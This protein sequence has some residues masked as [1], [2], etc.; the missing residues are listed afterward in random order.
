M[1]LL[2]CVLTPTIQAQNNP[3]YFPIHFQVEL[4]QPQWVQQMYSDDPNVFEVDRL[5]HEDVD[6]NNSSIL[7]HINN[8]Q[9]WRKE[10]DQY[11]NK[12]GFIR[13]L[14]NEQESQKYLRDKNSRSL[15][16]SR[17]SS[18]WECIGPLE[19]FRNGSTDSYSYQ[20]SIY[21]LDQS[22]SNSSILYAGTESGGVFK[23]FNKGIS[24]ILVSN[25]EEFVRGISA[26]E[27]HPSDQNK[28]LIGANR[29]IYS[30]T[31]AGNNWNEILF[32]N[33]VP[34]EIRFNPNDPNN[35]YVSCSSGFYATTD[36]G[37]NWNS[38]WSEPTYDI[39]FQPNNPDSIFALRGNIG[40]SSPELIRTVDGGINWTTSNQGWYVPEDN[41]SA[42]LAGG[43]IAIS[44]AAPNKIY[45]GLV[46][47]SKAGDLGWIGVYRSDNGGDSW[48]LPAG[49]IGGPYSSPNTMPWAIASDANN[50]YEGF[51]AFD[52][53]VSET[54]SDKL[55]VGTIR[56]SESSD[57][58]VSFVSIGGENSTRLSHMHR[59][60][61]DLEVNG[62][63]IWVASDGGINYSFNELGFHISTKRG[64]SSA[65][66]LGFDSGWN[67][68]I[69]VGG[70][71][72][73]GNSAF[74]EEFNSGE[75]THLGGNEEATGYLNPFNNKVYLG[76]GTTT[77]V[78]SLPN[79]IGQNSIQIGVLD[80]RP[81]ESLETLSSSEITFDPRY[82][83]HL[84][85][86]NDNQIWFSRNGGASF[87]LLHSF[88]T[89][90]QVLSIKI[91]RNNP[92]Y[93]YCS[94]RS[95]TTQGDD[96]NLYQSTD[97][98]N[99]WNSLTAPTTDLTGIAFSLNPTNA[100]E[101]WISSLNGTNGQKVFQSINGGASW[102]NKTTASLDDQ[103]IFDILFQ[104]GTNS[105][106]HLACEAGVRYWENGTGD[107]IDYSN[108]LPLYPLPLKFKPFYKENK[109]RL[110]SSGRGIW[111]VDFE[112]SSLPLA[113]PM[114]LTDSI[115]CERDS[116]S[117]DCHS[118]LTHDDVDWEWSFSPSPTFVDD[119]N[120]RNPKVVFGA[121]GNYDVTLTVTDENGNVSTKILSDM[122]KINA[123]CSVDT[124]PG[125]ALSLTGADNGYVDIGTL[126]I[127]S[128]NITI[129]S[130]IKPDDI[131][132]SNA[133]LVFSR[134]NG[135]AS[136][137]FITESRELRFAW[138]GGHFG[139][140]SG[141][142]VPQDEWSHV[143]L[144]V[145]PLE[146]TL[147]LNG[148]GVSRSATYNPIDFNSEMSIGRDPGFSNRCFTGEMDEVSIF[149]RALTEEE[150]RLM[151][152]LVLEPLND[153]TI[154]HYYQFNESAGPIIDKASLSHGTLVG[155]S[156]RS[157]SPIPVGSGIVE[158][159]NIIDGGEKDFST[160]DVRMVFPSTGTYPDGDVYVFKIN[161]DPNVLPHPDMAHEGQ[162]WIFNNYGNNTVF[163]ALDSIEFTGMT[164]IDVS[165][166]DKYEIFKR[167]SNSTDA[168]WG[169][170]LG[171]ADSGNSN[172]LKFG[173]S[174]NLNSFS[175]FGLAQSAILPLD[176]LSIQLSPQINHKVKVDWWTANEENVL[177]QE[178]QRSSNGR[179]FINVE[180]V[181]PTGNPR[182]NSY[183]VIDNYPFPGK[184]YYRIKVINS[185]GSFQFSE[186]KTL[187]LDEVRNTFELFPNPI[188]KNDLQ[189]NIQTLYRG[190][191]QFEIWSIEGRKLM[192]DNLEGPAKIDLDYLPAG[193]YTWRVVSER[194]MFA[195][196]LIVN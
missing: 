139:W 146:T 13:P 170:A 50:I 186:I 183:S 152:H 141:L 105:R 70:K 116:V 138:A 158:K 142:I 88:S 194:K 156:T 15:T 37:V 177:T 60:I 85:L 136:G 99:N 106:V 111:S 126:G 94:V 4:E 75:F 108:G 166:I 24:W 175:Q 28:I 164:N 36:G 134:P 132:Q 22:K 169:A 93:F 140:S 190:Q 98:G 167:S 18:T 176:F 49:Q 187:E 33:G 44:P 21:S 35:I 87:K 168:I 46:G 112:Q 38:I 137:L 90:H 45:A 63:D 154:K 66:M 121:S 57:G 155:T 103:K 162:Y 54:N 74:K 180:N 196:R 3:V 104:G 62:N 185:D 122:I 48:M 124:I 39:E 73:N 100:D 81:N 26:V 195:G 114:T 16:N 86:G 160:T 51:H 109:L 42:T 193:Q 131:Q 110:A 135:L 91:S 171:N 107:W 143:A 10:V 128:N 163:S 101:I 161:T 32:T 43:K 76:E 113:Q 11:L 71:L 59:N 123:S 84:Y 2:H 181:A 61:H 25:Q 31:N 129:S 56:L 118:I 5:F 30:T 92:N 120:K 127:N 83:N 20:A 97:G 165:Q 117:F 72:H 173:S 53:E 6:K 145:T 14:N 150:I 133:G 80:Y 157:N 58:G 27:I 159:I 174:V 149:D 144:V 178:I 189:L 69:L 1:L 12:S 82:A 64:I 9:H 153:P 65:E 8:Y 41:N 79:S 52:L 19:T 102:I 29:R 17:A 115:Y 23:S 68:D 96:I 125:G 55:W 89:G 77:L 182:V 78:K 191:Y 95:G 119:P 184:N 67:E 188:G 34:N 172:S 147:Y 151:R 130:W 192:S 40:S 179:E 148:V 47:N 7:I